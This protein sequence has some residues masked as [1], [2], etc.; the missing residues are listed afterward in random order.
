M[1]VVYFP[2]EEGDQEEYYTEHEAI[3]YARLSALSYNFCYATD[4]DAIMDF[5]VVHWAEKVELWSI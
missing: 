4:E 3:V 2:D 5:I 1:Y